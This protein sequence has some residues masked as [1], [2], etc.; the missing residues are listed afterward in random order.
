[1]G[2]IYVHVRMKECCRTTLKDLDKRKA[3][4]K[5]KGGTLGIKSLFKELGDKTIDEA[6]RAVSS[7]GG[8]ATNGVGGELERLTRAACAK[9][10]EK[11]AA[12]HEGKGEQEEGAFWRGMAVAA[13]DDGTSPEHAKQ[14][15]CMFLSADYFMLGDDSIYIRPPGGGGMPPEIP[16][17]GPPEP[18]APKPTVPDPAT[19]SDGVKPIEKTTPGEPGKG[20]EQN[21]ESPQEKWRR[22]QEVLKGGIA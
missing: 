1:M 9:V 16:G 11:H 19:P 4:A 15:A 5:I 3:K 22:L 12:A 17:G 14:Y 2:D 6:K 8:K 13:K 7:G 18:I 20:S 10:C 21:P